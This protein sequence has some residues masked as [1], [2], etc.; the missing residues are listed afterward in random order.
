VTGTCSLCGS[1]IKDD[2]FFVDLTTNFVRYKGECRKARSSEA[3]V[4]YI[5][6]KASPRL[7]QHDVI[8]TGLWGD[9]PPADSRSTVAVHISHARKL[10]RGWNVAI[11]N[12]SGCGYRLRVG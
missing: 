2:E 1:G 10:M 8:A 6:N 11:I 9:H 3:E 5:L 7:V 12:E 4:L